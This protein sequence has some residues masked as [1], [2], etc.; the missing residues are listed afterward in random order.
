MGVLGKSRR[1]GANHQAILRKRVGQSSVRNQI[2]NSVVGERS[3]RCHEEQ[4][5]DPN[6]T[7]E[8]QLK[9]GENLEGKPLAAAR[10]IGQVFENV[11]LLLFHE[12]AE[13]RD[14]Q[15]PTLIRLLRQC[16]GVAG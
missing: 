16:I 9:T 11:G 15:Q 8:R 2:K 13:L 14:D 5:S 3:S 4:E 6:L 10:R 7:A 12:L 1:A